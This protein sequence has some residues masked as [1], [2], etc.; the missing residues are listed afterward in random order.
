MREAVRAVSKQLVESP[1]GAASEYRGYTWHR[2][3][4][5]SL[6]KGTDG[7]DALYLRLDQG[8]GA[9]CVLAS[10]NEWGECIIGVAAP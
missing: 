10:S 5:I 2:R 9:A 3:L 6:R 1:T 7:F 8:Y 4:L